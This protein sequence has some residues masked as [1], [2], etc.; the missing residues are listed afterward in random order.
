MRCP[1]YEIPPRSLMADV[2]MVFDRSP[3]ALTAVTFD[4][5]SQG[6]QCN[7]L[8]GQWIGDHVTENRIDCNVKRYL[9]KAWNVRALVTASVNRVLGKQYKVI[10]WRR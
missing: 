1:D 8:L 7:I 4:V 5:M 10:V 6:D 2:R 3:V 9:R